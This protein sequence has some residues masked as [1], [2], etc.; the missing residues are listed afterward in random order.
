MFVKDLLGHEVRSAYDA[1]LPSIPKHLFLSEDAPLR[2]ARALANE[3][4][5]ERACVL[6]DERTRRAAGDACV[7]ALDAEGFRVS[8]LLLPDREGSSP[9]CD[10]LTLGWVLS[11][12]PDTNLVVAVGSGVVNDLAKW[13]AAT[14]NVPYAVL[15]TA[16][17]MNGYTSANVAPTVKGVK[18]L[19]PGKA[20][21]AV[22]AVPSVLAAAPYRMTTAGFGDLIA[23]PVSTA[24]WVVSRHLTDEPFSAALAALADRPDGTL[25][26]R[27]EGLVQGDPAS[28][29]ALFE[30]LALS[31]CAMTLHGSSLPASGGEHVIS[32][33]LDMMSAAD[34]APHDLHGRQVGV[35]TIVVAA[36]WQWLME[37]RSP[38]FEPELPPLDP[39]IWGAAAPAVR[40]QHAA[41][42]TV[43]RRACERLYVSG[44]WDAIRKAVRPHLRPPD[45]V[46]D[47]LLR[48]KGATCLADIGCSRARFLV[49][50]RHGSAMR[51]RLTC[52]DLVRMAGLPH[53]EVE[54][55]VDQ[56]V[57]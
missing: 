13:A 19:V 47:R 39:S 5:T 1:S 41:K 31:G 27:P 51:T 33:T 50:L 2:V 11:T 24:D 37:T 16:S 9:V 6:F 20:A 28:V 17:S 57:A 4:T 34:G 54:S 53:E 10:D 45:W 42:E 49:A 12:M 15:A 8:E 25:F 7:H 3:L 18:S 43:L 14:L 44:Y 36:L 29:R 21:R 30:A 40:K 38:S 48:A 32:H 22:A 23:K 55:I 46:K 26:A 56:W 35:A 52:L